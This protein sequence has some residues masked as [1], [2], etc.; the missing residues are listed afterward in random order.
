MRI[1]KNS[2]ALVL[3]ALLT[4]AAACNKT[5]SSAPAQA[6]EAE[7]RLPMPPPRPAENSLA[8]PQTLKVPA[9]EHVLENRFAGRTA[10]K[11]AMRGALSALDAKVDE[12][13]KLEEHHRRTMVT[14]APPDFKPEPVVRKARL[15][16]VLEKRKINAGAHPRFRLEL[17]NVGRE[18][19]DYQEYSPS[20]FVKNGRMIDSPTI[21]FFLTDTRKNRKELMPVVFRSSGPRPAGE[22]FTVKLMP[23]ET[24]H[25]VG[26]DDSPVENFKTL[27]AKGADGNI[28]TYRLHVELDDRPRPLTKG[29]IEANLRSGS[30]LEQIEKSHKEELRAAL[31]P[32]SSNAAEF[33]VTR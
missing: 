8:P 33:E 19:I 14:P 3:A 2:D 32:V 1:S 31:G 12:G 16:L 13:E 10:E 30:T 28:G 9:M 11:E 15:R 7:A 27:D 29:Y 24:L 6:P 23:G 18:P 22:T 20:I 26:D 17:T 4:I 25:S 21:R 5:P